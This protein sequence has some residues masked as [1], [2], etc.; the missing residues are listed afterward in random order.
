MRVAAL[1]G[2]KPISNCIEYFE[3]FFPDVYWSNI[4][5]GSKVLVLSNYELKGQAALK[6]NSHKI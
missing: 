2:C 1:S 3:T 6:E 4:Q 5:K